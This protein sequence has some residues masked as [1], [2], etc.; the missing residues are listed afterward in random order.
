M[1][2]QPDAFYAL[3]DTH[4]GIR[5]VPGGDAFWGQPAEALDALGGDWL[6]S[7][8]RCDTDW[9]NWE[10]HPAGDEFVYLL[11]GQVELLLEL[12]EGVAAHHLQGGG[13]VVVPRGI[14]HTARVF[15]PS[16]MFFITRGAGTEHRP[17]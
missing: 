5:R 7:E 16:R 17:A 13:A 6:V 12:P 4:G 15:G 2:F 10:R 8:F 3:L 11:E 14:W 9:A 1:R